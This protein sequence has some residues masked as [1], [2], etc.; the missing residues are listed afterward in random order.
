MQKKERNERIEITYCMLKYQ[1]AQAAPLYP[2]Q[3]SP[4]PELIYQS[5]KTRTE[6]MNN[7]NTRRGINLNFIHH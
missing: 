5:F 7:N 4:E 3:I 2:P 1:S 6:V